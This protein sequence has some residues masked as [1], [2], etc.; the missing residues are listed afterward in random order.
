MEVTG[1]ETEWPLVVARPLTLLERVRKVAHLRRVQK[2]IQAAVDSKRKAWEQT[3]SGLLVSVAAVANSLAEAE[4]EVREMALG[5]YAVTGEKAVAPGVNVR[6]VT[7]LE[8]EEA[9]AVAWVQEHY[10][11]SKLLQLNKT[12]FEKLVRGRGMPLDCVTITEVP[13][14]TIA[15]DLDKVLAEQ[16][17]QG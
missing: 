13:Q 12:A 14:A 16:G 9:E 7:K 4:K 17:P 5:S 3:H 15:A 8:Y 2:V 1:T 6:L 11:S 10:L